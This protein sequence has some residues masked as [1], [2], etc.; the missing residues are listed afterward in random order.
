MG[1]TSYFD[2]GIHEPGLKKVGNSGPERTRAKIFEQSRTDSGQDQE[3][4]ENFGSNRTRPNKIKKISDRSGLGSTKFKNL[5]PSRTGP[6]IPGTD[7]TRD[8]KLSVSLSLRMILRV[9]SSPEFW[10][11]YP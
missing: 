3:K 8:R 7:I 9:P 2:S 4:I 5:E 10:L 1:L 11:V 6:W